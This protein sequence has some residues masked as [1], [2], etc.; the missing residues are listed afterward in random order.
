M[1]NFIK[2]LQKTNEKKFRIEKIIKRKRNKLYV[3][4]KGYDSSF[5]SQI[6]KKDI[7]QMSE[8]FSESK[9]SG[10]KV[11]LSNYATKTDLK[12]ATGV[13]SKF[14][15]QV[16]LASL[17]SNVDKSDIDKLR[18]VSSDLSSLKSKVNKLDI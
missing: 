14:A 9:S 4:W 10:G 15:K 12:I 11:D 13:T 17:K 2:K 3:K 16:D 1:E 7:L 18:N 5:N 8:Y 6:D